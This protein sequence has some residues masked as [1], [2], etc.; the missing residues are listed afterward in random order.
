VFTGVVVLAL[1][2]LGFKAGSL[3]A[4]ERLWLILLA[5]AA[6]A[7]HQS[8]LPLA[9]GLASAARRCCWVARAA[10]GAQG[11]ARMA[12]PVVVAGLALVAVNL[13]GPRPRLAV[14]LRLRSS[15]RR[16]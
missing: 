14:A 16:G 11:E 12:F 8:H 9:L 6:I 7:C 10:A 1:W 4:G 2:L 13:A 5:T 15:W 3:S